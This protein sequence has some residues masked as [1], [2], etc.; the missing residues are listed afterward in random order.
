MAASVLLH[1]SNGVKNIHLSNTE[2][3]M[4]KV[5]TQQLKAKVMEALPKIQ[6]LGEDDVQLSFNGL[7]LASDYSLSK[8]GIKPN[9]VVHLVLR[10]QGG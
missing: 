4:S 10:V 5:T 6:G 9:S 3:Q 1:Y 8:Y 2:E 7:K